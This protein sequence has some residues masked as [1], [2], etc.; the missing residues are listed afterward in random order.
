MP[1]V[2]PGRQFRKRATEIQRRHSLAIVDSVEELGRLGLVSAVSAEVRV[3]RAALLFKLYLINNEEAFFGFY[4]VREHLRRPL[5]EARALLLDFD[6][7]VCS[8]FAGLPTPVIAAEL[9][10][11]LAAQGARP[12]HPKPSPTIR[13]RCC[14][15]RS[16][17]PAISPMRSKSTSAP[18]RSKPRPPQRLHPVAMTSSAPG[19]PQDGHWSS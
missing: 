7:P 16:P 17:S 12:C 5:T 13:T 2:G 1:P 10:G 4:P 8:V 18:A 6:G 3:H 19:T 11:I 15:T 14:A 9:R